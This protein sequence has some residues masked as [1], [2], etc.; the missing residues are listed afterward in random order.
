[1]PMPHRTQ[2]Q[3]I[4]RRLVGKDGG[5]R[6]TELRSILA[7][8]PDYKNGP[9]A[10]HPQVGRTPRSRSRASARRSCTVTRCQVRREGVGA[11][12][13]RRP[14]ERRQV[15]AAAGALVDPDQDGRLRVHDASARAG[16][17]AAARRA[18]SARRDPGADRR[19]ARGPRRRPSAPRGAAGSRCDGAL[20]G[21][22]G[23]ARRAAAVRAELE[24]GRDRPPRDRG[25]DEAGRGGRSAVE[26]IGVGSRTAGGRRLR[27]RRR[28]PGPAARGALAPDRP[29]PRLPAP[30]RR[31]RGRAA[32]ALVPGRRWWTRPP[33][34][35]TSWRRPAPAHACG[36]HRRSSTASGSAPAMCSGTTTS[37][38]FSSR[39][40]R[41]Y[42]CPRRYALRG[43]VA[44]G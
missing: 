12:R 10:R 18:R 16:A 5:E 20:P 22:L 36:G 27:A 35:T 44:A 37:W 34:S 24:S 41:S 6:I 30:P 32:A 2:M 9:Y 39:L 11:D 26:Q 29:D 8:L 40:L 25:G 1:M 7:E 33:R 19:R 13:V 42:A 15:V 38:R 4:K 17:D 31:H 23:A 21:R 43:A 14:A 28:E 3:V